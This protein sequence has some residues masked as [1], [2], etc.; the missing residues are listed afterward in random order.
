MRGSNSKVERIVITVS[1]AIIVAAMCVSIGVWSYISFN[2]LEHYRRVY[3]DPVTVTATVTKHSVDSDSDGDTHKSHVTY[4]VDKVR[5]VDYTYES[6]S[7]ESMLTPV[8][9]QV[10]IQVSPEDPSV[11]I[12]TLKVGIFG[13]CICLV[14]VALGLAL[15][16]GAVIRRMRSN[17]LYAECRSDAI[18]RDLRLTVAAREGIPCMS[19]CLMFLILLYLRY[20]FVFVDSPL[21]AVAVIVFVVLL[22]IFFKTIRDLTRIKN[23]N[24]EIRRDILVDKKI[25]SDSEGGDSYV[26]YYESRGRKWHKTVSVKKYTLAEVG[27][28]ITAV[29]F[30]KSKKPVL[31]YNRIGDPG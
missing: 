11:Q 7:S 18:K 10:E 1:F 25:E 21:I 4:I 5:Y 2:N 29:Y 30:K 28:C 24:Y 16:Y 17:I 26:L 19:L 13:A 3:Q 6:K 15:L 8:G 31:H 14:S 23:D 22:C 27:D 9:Q 20:P 12:N